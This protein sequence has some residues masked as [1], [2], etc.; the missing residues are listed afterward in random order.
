MKNP[1][2]LH[3]FCP[4]FLPNLIGGL[5]LYPAV[6]IGVAAPGVKCNEQSGNKC[7]D[8]SGSTCYILNFEDNNCYVPVLEWY[9]TTGVWTC[10]ASTCKN[11]AKVAKTSINISGCTYNIS[12][13]D[14]CVD[15]ENNKNTWQDM[16]NGILQKVTKCTIDEFTASICKIET[17]YQ[18]AAGYYGNPTSATSGCT[19]C[20]SSATGVAGL[21]PAGATSES[22][23]YINAEEKIC[24][25]S[26]CF[27][28]SANYEYVK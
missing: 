2:F 9:G 28:C 22:Q 5:L 13:C 4:Y 23:C 12:V 10:N 24:D 14:P 19:K 7:T 1:K 6:A 3:I 21:S 15:C 20:P 8:E 16:G 27:K 11:K 25:D 26:G 17:T 18:C